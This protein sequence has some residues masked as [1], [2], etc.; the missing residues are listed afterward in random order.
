MRWGI[1]TFVSFKPSLSH[2]PDMQN[3]WFAGGINA[4]RNERT[5]SDTAPTN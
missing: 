3:Y 4:S 1:I 2:F 5:R